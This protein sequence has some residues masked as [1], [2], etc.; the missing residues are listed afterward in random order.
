[1]DGK[2]FDR[3]CKEDDLTLAKAL[4]FVQKYELKSTSGDS[5][6]EVNWVRGQQQNARRNYNAGENSNKFSVGGGGETMKE[7]CAHCGYLN[8]RSMEWRFKNVTCNR[9]KQRGHMEAVCRTK[10]V[11]L[12]SEPQ[13]S[14]IELSE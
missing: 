12:V 6:V 11:H 13:F 10:F 9:C 8:H 1:M 7:K 3:L 14:D 4:A 5:N 2:I